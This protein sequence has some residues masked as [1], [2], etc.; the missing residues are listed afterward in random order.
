MAWDV[1][2]NYET[3]PLYNFRLATGSAPAHVYLEMEQIQD[4]PSRRSFAG[5]RTLVTVR[6]TEHGASVPER[7]ELLCGPV[8]LNPGQQ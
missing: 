4:P 8:P 1:A 7:G 3:C 2:T 5:Q 6:L